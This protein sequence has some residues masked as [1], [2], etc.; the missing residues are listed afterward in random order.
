MD[1]K[2]HWEKIYGKKKI[3][4]TSWYQRIPLTSM[5][6][7]ENTAMNE[8]GAIIDVGGGASTLVDHLLTAGYQ[9]L[10]V[11]DISSVALE[12]ARL[13]LM[14]R[15]REVEWIEADVIRFDSPGPFDLWHDRAV[16]HF[17][18]Q[19]DQRRAYI[20]SLEEH[21]KP[22]GHVIIA[23]F[24][25]DGP[26]KCSNLETVRYT[27]KSL[28]RELGPHFELLESIPEIHTTPKNKKQSFIYCR[29]R[30]L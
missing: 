22:N 6:L 11:L 28:S 14:D 26:E 12:N 25:V 4:E 3:T 2:A 9:N 18:T 5:T 10:T 23:T 21:V 30:R 13:R 1:R 20:A 27:P 15:E 29:F 17:F 19:S 7:I 24:S 8:D 16:F